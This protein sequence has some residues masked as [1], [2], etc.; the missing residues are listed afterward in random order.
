MIFSTVNERA[1]KLA[2]IGSLKRGSKDKNAPSKVF[3]I[4]AGG[5]RGSTYRFIRSG[6]NTARVAVTVRKSMVNQ[7][8]VT[9]EAIREMSHS[10]PH[11]SSVGRGHRES[12][13]QEKYSSSSA[14]QSI[15]SMILPALSQIDFDDVTQALS[16]RKQSA[17][18]V[19][20]LENENPDKLEGKTEKS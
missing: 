14:S 11:S 5:S 9:K 12:M 6:N 2:H 13:I 10:C 8:A 3:D 19:E 16:P 18:S 1:R 4:Y 17:E 20:C 15:A 7:F